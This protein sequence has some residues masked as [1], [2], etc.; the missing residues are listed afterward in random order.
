[1]KIRFWKR[2]PA[3]TQELVIMSGITRGSEVGVGVF[4]AGRLIAWGRNETAA[5][6]VYQVSKA[7]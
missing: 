2:Q 5:V 1:M 4:E 7:A 3:E 6:A